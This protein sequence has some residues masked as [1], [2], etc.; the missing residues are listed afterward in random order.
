MRG[1]FASW[2]TSVLS[3]AVATAS[4]ENSDQALSKVRSRFV[5]STGAVCLTDRGGGRDVGSVGAG[6]RVGVDC[7]SRAHSRCHPTGHRSASADKHGGLERSDPRIRRDTRCQANETRRGPPRQRA[8]I[9]C[10]RGTGC[11]SVVSARSWVRRVAVLLLACRKKNASHGASCMQPLRPG[12][13]ERAEERP[14]YRRP[15][16]TGARCIRPDDPGTR[17]R[18]RSGAHMDDASCSVMLELKTSSKKREY[19]SMNV[20]FVKERRPE[21][22]RCIGCCSRP[23]PLHP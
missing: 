6:D 5:P 15:T 3:T 20:V 10:S 19:V 8:S 22:I 2:K 1:R 4:P 11:D 7:S 14:L 12:R 17:W 18:P 23:H 16:G 13:S 9:F 21:A